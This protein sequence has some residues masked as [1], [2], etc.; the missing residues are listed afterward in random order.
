MQVVQKVTGEAHVVSSGKDGFVIFRPAPQ[1]RPW[2]LTLAD[3]SSP[4]HCCD[5]KGALGLARTYQKL[6]Q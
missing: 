3:V 2:G 1:H 6:Q 5:V 4:P